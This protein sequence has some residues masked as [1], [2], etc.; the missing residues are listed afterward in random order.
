MH[1]GQQQP[2]DHNWPTSELDCCAERLHSADPGR[3]NRRRR[4]RY[5]DLSQP[6]RNSVRP[7]DYGRSCTTF[8]RH[9]GL[10]IEKNQ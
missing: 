8:H 3:K 10:A 6:A 1:P 9:L 5:R 7:L 4:R 2:R